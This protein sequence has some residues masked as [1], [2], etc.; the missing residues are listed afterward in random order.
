MTRDNSTKTMTKDIE[1]P[2]FA[3]TRVFDA[4]REK[5]WK[6]FTESE[7]L[8][9]W[10]GPK[11]FKMLKGRL[12]LRPEGVFH[13]CMRSPMGLRMCGKFVYR[14]I[15]K[16][17]KIVFVN[18]F[19]DEENNLTRHPLEPNWPLEVLNTLTLT[20]HNGQTT[21]ALKAVP[22]NA[23]DLENKTFEDGRSSMREGFSGTWDQLDAYLAK[24]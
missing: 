4:P 18:S 9:R 2:E 8:L 14:E 19:S 12:D 1:G 7:H 5:V 3:I 11:G 21:L 20:E 22:L 15:I 16:P 13:Y 6:A 10:W 24:A 23:T 17:E